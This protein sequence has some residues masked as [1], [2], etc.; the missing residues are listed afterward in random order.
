MRRA[1]L[2]AAADE[3]EVGVA[4]HPVPARREEPDEGGGARGRGALG[5]LQ[6]ASRGQQ[7]LAPKEGTERNSTAVSRRRVRRALLVNAH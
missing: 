5:L 7:L 4:V 2:V 6:V 1:R 3:D